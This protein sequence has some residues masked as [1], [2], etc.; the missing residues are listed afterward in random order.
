MLD[1]LPDLMSRQR[2]A[3]PLALAAIAALGFVLAL[4]L[5]QL[6]WLALAA[7]APPA[8]PAPIAAPAAS[9]PLPASLANW[10]LFGNAVPM[11]DSRGLASAPD[12]G[13]TLVLR[14][15]FAQDDPR[16]GRAIIA[17]ADGS[18]RA[19]AP[20]DEVAAGV[21]LD[22]VYGDRVM[23]SRAGQLEALRLARPDGAPAA[24]TQPGN[25]ARQNLRNTAA[26]SAPRA[27]S[28]PVA[29][30]FVN[31]VM[32]AVNWQAA[33]A[34]IGVDAAAIA[35]N[36]TALPVIEGGRFVGVRLQA[37]PDATLFNK[38]GLRPDD[39]VTAVNGI[40]LDSPARAQE[41]A[42]SLANSTSASVEIRRDGKPLTLAV[43]LPR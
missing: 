28:A 22:S 5:A 10:H 26:A 43:S 25:V 1:A 3:R 31:P 7:S 13:L 17:S 11:A 29:E 15:V 27:G 24:G 14:G 23:L 39:V 9:T 19:Y 6:V 8:P 40:E 18:E 34:T 30:P 38:L 12:T 42:M 41:I 33:S 2:H 37:G 16:A 35:K 32:G 4:L 21:T 20:G 36:V